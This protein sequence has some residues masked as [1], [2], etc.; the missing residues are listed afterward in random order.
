M[1]G[2]PDATSSTSD[3][4]TRTC[5]RPTWPWASWPRRRRTRATTAT[6]PHGGSRSS[7]WP[8][9]TCTG[10]DSGSGST[11]IHIGGP[12]FA[13]ADVRQVPLRGPAAA[14]DDASD[15]GEAFFEGLMNAWQESWPKPRVIV[16]SFPH[17]P[18]TACVDHT[19]ME[20]LVAFAREHE[21]S[22]VHDFAYAHLGFARYLPP[23]IP[24]APGAPPLAAG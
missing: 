17:N 10:G 23:S 15:P 1:P 14:S 21:G 13:G 4:G 8:S 16:L 11:P 3:S 12:L 5:R 20:R 6:R 18:T 22:L 9:P 19:F 2:E 24:P 7:A